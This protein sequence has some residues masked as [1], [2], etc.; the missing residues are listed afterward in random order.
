MFKIRNK[1][2]SFCVT[3][4]ILFVLGGEHGQLGQGDRVNKLRPTMVVAL[5]GVH[6]SQ[7]SCGWSHS[8]ALCSETNKVKPPAYFYYYYYFEFIYLTFCLSLG[9]H[10]GKW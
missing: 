2:T 8:V 10:L 5:E 9:L 6:I 7:I 1:K 4:T 3:Q